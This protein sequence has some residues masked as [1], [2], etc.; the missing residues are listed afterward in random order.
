MLLFNL[1]KFSQKISATGIPFGAAVAFGK[2]FAGTPVVMNLS[3][4]N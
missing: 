4:F 1:S 2:D 3:Y